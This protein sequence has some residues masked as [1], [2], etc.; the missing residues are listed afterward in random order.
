MPSMSNES[1]SVAVT[2]RNGL[3][4]DMFSYSEDMHFPLLLDT[5]GVSL[6][7]ISPD[8]PTKE[9]L[10]WHSASKMGGY[11]TPGLQNSQF[12]IVPENHDAFALSPGIFSPDNDG[13][14]DNLFISYT[15]PE[16]GIVATVTIY[17]A[18]GHL[19]CNLVNN[20]LCGTTGCWS[21]DGV[22]NSG[23]KALIGM[24]VVL[25]ETFDLN[26]KVKRYKKTAVLGGKL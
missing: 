17:D 10:N 22:D 18:T 15:F 23:G 7:R 4:I 2:L 5:E 24:Y 19:T 20:E 1:G 13:Y 9:R 21:W 25:L 16:P 14:N 6:E 11:A 12:G 26:G 3:I 8:R